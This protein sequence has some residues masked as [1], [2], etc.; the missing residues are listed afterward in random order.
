MKEKIP[1]YI[2]KCLAEWSIFIGPKSVFGSKLDPMS[3]SFEQFLKVF[4]KNGPFV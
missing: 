1:E 4:L 2:L 3:L